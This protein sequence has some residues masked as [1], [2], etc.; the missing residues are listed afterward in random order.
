MNRIERRW[1]KKVGVFVFA[2][3]SFLI[4]LSCS[5]FFSSPHDWWTVLY[6]KEASDETIIITTSY[7]KVLLGGGVFTILGILLYLVLKI[8]DAYK[9]TT[10]N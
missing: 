2:W 1:N 9:I 8:I 10:P 4:W 3:L 5:S 7:T 6:V